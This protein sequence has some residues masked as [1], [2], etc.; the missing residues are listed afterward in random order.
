MNK[1]GELAG[2]KNLQDIDDIEEEAEE[3]A[4][5]E[6]EDEEDD[7]NVNEDLG[8]EQYNSEEDENDDEGLIVWLIFYVNNCVGNKSDYCALFELSVKSILC[9][10]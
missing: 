1:P 7:E 8:I 3:D 10:L 5:Q 9:K 4:E 2:E 6:S